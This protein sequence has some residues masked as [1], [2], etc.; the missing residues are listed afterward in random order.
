MLEQAVEQLAPAAR[1]PPV[2]S[3]GKL[4]QVVIQMLQA[5]NI[6]EGFVKRSKPD[7]ARFFNIAEGSLEESRY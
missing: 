4:V 6:A 7:K 3:E 2:E 1:L 5:D